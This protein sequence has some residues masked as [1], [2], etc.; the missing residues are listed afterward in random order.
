MQQ[1]GEQAFSWLESCRIKNKHSFCYRKEIK[2]ETSS[3]F[4]HNISSHHKI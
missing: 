1:S 2:S 3:H 4:D